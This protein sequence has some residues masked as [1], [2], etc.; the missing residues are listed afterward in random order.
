MRALG[1]FL[2]LLAVW[3]VLDGSEYLWLGLLAAGLGTALAVALATPRRDRLRPGRLPGFVVFFL[4][5]SVRGG[6]DVAL[7]AFR[8]RLP[9][10]PHCFDY[11]LSLPAGKPRLLLVSV[12]S[13]LPGTLSADL[14]A[15]GQTVRIHAINESP[16]EAVRALEAQVAR[17]FAIPA[18]VA[19]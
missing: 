9:I 15:D 16:Q 17:L 4:V 11:A 8:P 19:S 5:E 3:W 2:A 7:R 12:T 10:H 14:S 18:E 6:M 13:L 1:V